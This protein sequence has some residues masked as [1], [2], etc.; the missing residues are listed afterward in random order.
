MQ[1][2]ILSSFTKYRFKYC[3][4]YKLNIHPIEE[5]LGISEMQEHLRK[6]NSPSKKKL[7]TKVNI[8][9]DHDDFQ[10]IER[11]IS[12]PTYNAQGKFEPLK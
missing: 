2:I 10:H 3:M 9:Q 1:S 8:Q 5:M 12:S 6:K 11:E 7:N 4:D